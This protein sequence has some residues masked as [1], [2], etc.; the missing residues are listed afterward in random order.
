MSTPSSILRSAE[1]Y[2]PDVILMPW[3]VP[4]SKAA[5]RLVPLVVFVLTLAACSGGNP[6]EPVTVAGTA[7]DAPPS[8]ENTTALEQPQDPGADKP[9]ISLASLPIG[10]PEG[11][12]RDGD[13]EQCIHVTWIQSSDAIPE[14]LGVQVTGARFVPPVYRSGSRS[15][16]RP[17]CEG[18]VFRGSDLT[19]DLSIRPVR[20][21][22]TE[23]LDNPPVIMSLQGQVLCTDLTSDSCKSFAG[24]V[25]DQAQTL[26]LKLPAAPL[27]TPEPAVGT[28]TDTTPKTRTSNPPGEPGSTPG[29]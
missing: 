9:D 24:E 4:M 17:T 11:F 29:G 1:P 25:R 12:S 3:G 13:G 26:S 15:C 23:L 28:G 21:S 19:C 7:A 18:H 5:A 20:E 14:G 8:T 6:T 22:E 10:D 16:E 2:E 27:D